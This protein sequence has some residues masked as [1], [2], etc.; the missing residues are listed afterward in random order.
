MARAPHARRLPCRLG[1]D[2]DLLRQQH[3]ISDPASWGL[4]YGYWLW[5]YRWGFHPRDKMA[6][7]QL[8]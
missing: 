6:L 3:L 8:F 5:F 1:L 4:E 7:I 2:R